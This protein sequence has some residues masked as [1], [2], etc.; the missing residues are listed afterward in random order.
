M[1]LPCGAEILTGYWYSCP[2]DRMD[3]G[4]TAREFTL[5]AYRYEPG[6]VYRLQSQLADLEDARTELLLPDSKDA[7]GV[8]ME[9]VREFLDGD[10]DEAIEL[11]AAAEAEVV[12][13][14]AKRY[15][16]AAEK[17]HEAELADIDRWASWSDLGDAEYAVIAANDGK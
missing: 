15:R 1:K 6:C 16:K 2:G 14:V 12:S 13:S 4:Q 9:A 8:L 7:D 5:T 10:S 17:R 11:R 3:N